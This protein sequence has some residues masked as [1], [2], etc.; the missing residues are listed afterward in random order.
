MVENLGVLFLKNL[1]DDEDG[2]LYI[3]KTEEKFFEPDNGKLEKINI[4]EKIECAVRIY[5]DNKLAF[6]Y[7]SSPDEEKV[8]AL[9]DK[10]REILPY[11]KNREQ[12]SF[13]EKKPLPKIPK[14]YDKNYDSLLNEELGSF[15]VALEKKATDFDNRIKTTRGTQLSVYKESVQIV[16]N[17]GVDYFFEKTGYFVEMVVVAEENGETGDS[18]KVT[19]S[20][21][22]DELSLEIAVNTAES[23]LLSIGGNQPSTGKY[24]VIIENKAASLLLSTLFS[25]FNYE[26]IYKK[27]SPLIDKLNK[28]I[29]SKEVNVVLNGLNTIGSSAFPFD[30]EGVCS[31]EINI[32]QEGVLSNYIYDLEYAVIAGKEPSG[33][34]VREEVKAPPVIK[35]RNFYIKEGKND[36][37][38]FVN[39]FNEIIVVTELMGLHT[40]DPVTWQFSLGAKGFLYKNGKIDSPLQQF[41]IAGD[42]FTLLEDSKPLNDLVFTG[43]TG[44]PSL[45]IKE[46]NIAGK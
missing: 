1:K 10:I 25:S 30:D 14:I 15:T 9:M 2:E 21:F 12:F 18:W 36:V 8:L 42:I 17:K 5:S 41:T 3:K 24:P 26:N 34:S 13:S 43:S 32:I 6:G 33:S 7:V 28:K 46:I 31:G 44:S 45:F 37:K 39:T 19:H 11:Q 35:P 22:F 27:K 40:L 29:A 38:D 23:A 16:N 4:S 20:H